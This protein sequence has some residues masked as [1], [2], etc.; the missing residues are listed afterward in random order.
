[1]IEFT[2]DGSGESQEDVVFV[3]KSRY[4][5]WISQALGFI[6]TYLGFLFLTALGVSVPDPNWSTKIGTFILWASLL[7]SV[8]PGIWGSPW[9]CPPKLDSPENHRWRSFGPF[10]RSEFLQTLGNAGSGV[11]HGFQATMGS[12]DDAGKRR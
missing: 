11:L 5:R 8:V 6:F 3:E 1:V 10:N 7:Y 2:E 9:P 4:R 12:L